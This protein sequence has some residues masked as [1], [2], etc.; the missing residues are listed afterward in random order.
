MTIRLTILTCL[1]AASVAHAQ[2]KDELGPAPTFSVVR[3]LKPKEGLVVLSR[4]ILAVEKVPVVMKVNRN[5][6]VIDVITLV[7]RQ[8]MRQV[9]IYYSFSDGR[10]ITPDGKQ[11]PIDEVWKRLKPNLVI[12]VSGDFKQPAEA[13]LRALSAETLVLIPSPPK[14]SEPK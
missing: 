14:K 12:A 2:P 9:D 10:V 6:N 11:L 13:Y 8:V 4:E 1:L 7:D 3:S 5:G